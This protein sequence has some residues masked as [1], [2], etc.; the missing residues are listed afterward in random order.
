M[1]ARYIHVD[2]DYSVPLDAQQINLGEFEHWL[3]TSMSFGHDQ[4]KAGESVAM[5]E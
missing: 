4:D 5:V 3:L 2:A 1:A